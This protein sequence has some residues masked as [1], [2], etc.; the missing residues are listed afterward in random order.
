MTDHDLLERP[1]GKAIVAIGSEELEDLLGSAET[2]RE[3]DTGI[4]GSIRVLI[5]AGTAVV[6]EQTSAGEL[7][8]RRMPST[9]DAKRFVEQR[10]A[11]YERMWDGCGCKIDYGA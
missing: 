4:S 7:L 5:V 9:E 11:A 8:L 3:S 6:Q 2:V 10:V 1:S